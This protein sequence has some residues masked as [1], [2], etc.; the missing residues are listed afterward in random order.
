MTNP[1]IGI[2]GRGMPAQRIPEVP[3]KLASVQVDVHFR[4]Y[5]TRVADAGGLP[6]QL[7]VASDP[8]RIAERL[9]A[10]VLSGGAD[11][12]PARYGRVSEPGLQGID[13]ERD[14]FEFALLSRA[15][16]RGIPILGI[17]R[18]MQFMNVVLGGTMVQD[19]TPLQ[20]DVE[21]NFSDGPPERRAHRVATEAGS[22]ARRLYGESILTTSSHHQAVDDLGKDLR[23][24]GWADDGTI[25]I[26]EHMSLPWLG[27]QW[28]AEWHEPI[29]SAFEWLVQTSYTATA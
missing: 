2:T 16:L 7:S 18:G 22:L 25:E 1:L 19:I 11:I 4:N 10:L 29:D 5:A 15:M 6:V 20:V 14:E 8:V 28:H 24:T 9:D 26:L 17:C 12:D 3:N 23:V 13:P 27:V 21:H